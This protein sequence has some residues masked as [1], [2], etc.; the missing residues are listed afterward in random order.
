MS[1]HIAGAGHVL[2]V[3]DHPQHRQLARAFLEQAGYRVSFAEPGGRWTE[4]ASAWLALRVAAGELAIHLEVMPFV[5]ATH[6]RHRIDRRRRPRGLATALDAPHA[7]RA[8][9][10]GSTFQP[11]SVRRRRR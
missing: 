1:A 5:T 2:V 8:D 4:E 10:G 6:P 7:T 11:R 9:S 3:D